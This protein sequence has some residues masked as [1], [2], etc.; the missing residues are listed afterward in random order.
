MFSYD[1]HLKHR[2]D[3]CLLFWRGSKSDDVLELYES[4]KNAILSLSTDL[5][6]LPK[7]LYIAFKQGKNNIVSIHLQNKSLKIWINA[8]KGDLDDPKK[9]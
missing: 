3:F 7:K 6:I 2:G 9:N 8:K 1:F 5:E 4:F